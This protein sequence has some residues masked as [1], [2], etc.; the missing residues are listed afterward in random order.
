MMF[1]FIFN[2]NETSKVIHIPTQTDY[3]EL[4]KP[5]L[6]SYL[7]ENEVFAL[8]LKNKKDKFELSLLLQRT[9]YNKQEDKQESFIDLVVIPISA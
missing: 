5:F 7:K 3:T 2:K 1:F 9:E 6:E 4:L 8:S